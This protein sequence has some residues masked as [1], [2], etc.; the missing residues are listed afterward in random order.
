MNPQSKSNPTRPQN[1]RSLSRRLIEFILLILLAM[2]LIAVLEAASSLTQLVAAAAF[3]IFA[4]A[5]QLEKQQAETRHELQSLAAQNQQL[6]HQIDQLLPHVQLP[7][8]SG[9]TAAPPPAPQPALQPLFA[10]YHIAPELGYA[11]VNRMTAG[12][13][14]GAR[15]LLAQQTSLQA[16]E[17]DSLLAS[18]AQNA[19]KRG[20]V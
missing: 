17:L 13:E 10:E 14:A 1:S 16:T 12:D 20:A 6:Q 3:I 19:Q 7:P 9:S 2:I 8:G 11:L 15:Q 18:L 5:Y 4:I